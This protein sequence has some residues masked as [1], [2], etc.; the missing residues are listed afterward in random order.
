MYLEVE[1]LDYWVF[2]SSNFLDNVTV[3]FKVIVTILT[4]TKDS[5]FSAFLPHLIWPNF[6]ILANMVD[7]H[8]YLSVVFIC[9]ALSSI[10]PYLYW[11]FMFLLPSS[12]WVFCQIFSWFFFVCRHSL[13]NMDSSIFF[14]FQ[15]PVPLILS[16]SSFYLGLCHPYLKKL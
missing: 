9:S 15:N 6:S 1:L 8:Q 10:F 3:F 5:Y 7:M 12:I 2:I 11:L 16:P 13:Y 14:S 4:S